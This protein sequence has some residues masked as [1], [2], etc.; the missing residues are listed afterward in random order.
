MISGMKPYGLRRILSNKSTITMTT[1]C[2]AVLVSTAVLG[3]IQAQEHKNGAQQQSSRGS[4]SSETQKNQNSSVQ[5]NRAY[6]D[7]KH[8]DWHQWNG[9]EDQTYNR[10]AQEHHQDSRDFSKGSEREQQQY[11]NWR[12]KHHDDH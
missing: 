1:F 8:R 5:N 12:H 6:Y 4:T 7:S 3:S 10:Y 11:W 9:Q 2:K